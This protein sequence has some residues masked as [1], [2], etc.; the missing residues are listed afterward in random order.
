MKRVI[1]ENQPELSYSVKESLRAIRTNIQFCGNDYKS[2]LFTSTTPGE[3]KS[4]VAFEVARSLA[5]L[6]KKVLFVDTDI[7]KSILVK[8]LSVKTEDKAR[9]KGLSHFLSGQNTI[10]DVMYSTDISNLYTIFAGPSVPNATEIFENRNFTSLMQAAREKFDYIILD[11]API[12]AAIDSSLIAKFC[13]GAILVVEPEANPT[14]LINR[15]VKQLS[16]SGIKIL[17]A[18]LNKVQYKKNNYYGK[19]YGSYYGNYYGNEEKDKK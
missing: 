16:A 12:T 7:R 4:T 3:G 18:I 9:L 10:N 13:D 14:R 19:Y 17:G 8:R 6:D 15:C 2:I 11:T 1:I 5:E